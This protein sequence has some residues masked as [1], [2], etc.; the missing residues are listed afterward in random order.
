[1]SATKGRENLSLQERGPDV[2]FFGAAD[3][4]GRRKWVQSKN[5]IRE[6]FDLSPQGSVGDY[7]SMTT[8]EL[9]KRGDLLGKIE[10]RVTR[11]AATLAASSS[12]A[13]NDWEATSSIDVIRFFYSNKLVH[14]IYGDELHL[15]QITQDPRRS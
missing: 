13:F 5:T 3:L 6:Q 11:G 12:A 2:N 10:L 15:R 4:Y 1:M 14:E 7:G 9:D 8:I